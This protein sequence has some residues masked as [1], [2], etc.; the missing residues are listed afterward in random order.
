[1]KKNFFQKLLLHLLPFFFIP[2][3]LPAQKQNDSLKTYTLGEHI[4]S[5]SRHRQ[6]LQDVGRN[7]TVIKQEEITKSQCHSLGDLL[8]LQTGMHITGSGMNYGSTERVFLRGANSYHTVILI[9]GVR[10]SD[11]SSVDNGLDLSELSLNNIEQIEIIKGSHSTL[12]GSSAI[13]G[14]INIITK[15]HDTSG[16]HVNASLSAGSSNG[17]GP[18]CP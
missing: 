7:V 5:V 9:D 12:F 18:A 17:C 15:T 8:S 3:L 11:P 13:A 1:M 6:N 10:I 14:V 2:L 4:F 16:V